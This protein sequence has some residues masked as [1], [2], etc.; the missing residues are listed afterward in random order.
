MTPFRGLATAA[1]AVAAAVVLALPAAS[2]DDPGTATLPI[3]ATPSAADLLVQMRGGQGVITTQMS[4][5]NALFRSRD[6]SP[7]ALVAHYRRLWGTMQSDWAKEQAQASGAHLTCFRKSQVTFA[8]S[9]VAFD[10][11]QFAFL[12]STLKLLGA[13]AALESSAVT[14]TYAALEYLYPTYLQRVNDQQQVAP[15]APGPALTLASI[16]GAERGANSSL[17]SYSDRL[18][19]AQAVAADYD[20]RAAALNARASAFPATLT[21]AN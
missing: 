5:L 17:K 21:C 13:K 8:A 15:N 11:M 7:Q 16:Q 3:A 1:L 14:G 12:D 10:L 9:K 19:A 6:A 18:A 4:N 20:G 2:A